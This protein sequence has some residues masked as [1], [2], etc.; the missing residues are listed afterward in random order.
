[1]TGRTVEVDLAG[2]K[3]RV[4]VDAGAPFQRRFG[5]LFPTRTVG[6]RRP[7]DLEIRWSRGSG[8]VRRNGRAIARGRTEES[9]AL[10]GEWAATSL[11]LR[12]L[13]DRALLLHAAW[14]DGPRGGVFLVG[15]H[16]SGKSTLSLA[17]SLRHG[18]RVVADDVVALDAKGRPRPVE[19]PVRIKPGAAALLPELRNLK[20]NLAPLRAG[21][22]VL[23]PLQRRGPSPRRPVRAV[24]ILERRGSGPARLRPEGE[25]RGLAALARHV[26]NFR[27]RPAEA[28]PALA[29]IVSRAPVWRLSGGTLGERCRILSMFRPH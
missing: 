22:P 5:K 24:F 28:L 17:L 16:G 7:A 15:R 11:A 1:M 29:R 14:V 8:E 21:W 4:R 23:V 3:V 9:V 10:L 6:D 20:I 25:G 13:R 26:S 12:R 18:W 19:R 27:E 2:G